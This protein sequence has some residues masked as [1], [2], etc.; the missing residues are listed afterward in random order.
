MRSYNRRVQH[1]VRV[2]LI[3]HQIVEQPVSNTRLGPPNKM[4]M[5][6]LVLAIALRQV[7]PAHPGANH[8]KNSVHK[9]PV[10]IRWT[11][12]RTQPTRKQPLYPTPLRLSQLISQTTLLF[13][14]RQTQNGQ[15]EDLYISPDWP[16]A[17]ACAKS[18]LP[19]FNRSQGELIS[20][21]TP[22]LPKLH[23]SPVSDCLQK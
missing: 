23:L 17:E 4:F 18:S 1:Q 19:R 8:Q 16:S 3:S 6:A 10:V 12:N 2:L 22:L 21:G 20:L 11:T 7:R 15:S 13:A 9:P 5:H 14:V